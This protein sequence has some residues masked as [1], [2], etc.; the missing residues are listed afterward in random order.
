[1]AADLTEDT[2]QKLSKISHS[3]TSPSQPNF[4]LASELES[5]SAKRSVPFSDASSDTRPHIGKRKSFVGT[6]CELVSH[7]PA[8]GIR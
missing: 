3:T 4:F 7:R 5:N 1:M 8:N 6:V 2:S